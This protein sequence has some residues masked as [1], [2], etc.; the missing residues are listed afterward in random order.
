MVQ[1]LAW[2]NNLLSGAILQRQR[3]ISGPTATRREKG[4]CDE[5]ASRAHC[6]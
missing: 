4:Q 2:R 5:V 6:S 3:A 1:L